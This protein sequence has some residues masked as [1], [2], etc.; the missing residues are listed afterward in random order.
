M[1]IESVKVNFAVADR[2]SRK[3]ILEMMS[4]IVVDPEIGFYG[5]EIEED[6]KG[7]EEAPRK[8]RK[9]TRH[10]KAPAEGD[11]KRTT[12]SSP[13]EGGVKVTRRKM[14]DGTT[15]ENRG[16]CQGGGAV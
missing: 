7:A 6:G 10:V 1:K 5:V 2:I 4:E 15:I 9:Y 8:K 12:T 11:S 16:N 3:N 13:A 14:A